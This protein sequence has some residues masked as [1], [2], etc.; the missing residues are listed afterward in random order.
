MWSSKMTWQVEQARLASHAPSKSI[1]FLCATLTS[2]KQ[3]H[4]TSNQINTYIEYVVADSRVNCFL[5]V[6]FQV[7]EPTSQQRRLLDFDSESLLLCAQSA[8]LQFVETGNKPWVRTSPAVKSELFWQYSQHHWMLIFN[9]LKIQTRSVASVLMTNHIEHIN[10][11][12][13]K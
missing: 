2:V 11:F 1:S 7:D 3:L 13:L 8:Q 9:Y 6:V 12:E 10:N 5:N 4:I